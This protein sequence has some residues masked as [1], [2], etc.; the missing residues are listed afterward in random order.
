M[1]EWGDQEAWLRR[2][3]GGIRG[4]DSVH[5]IKIFAGDYYVPEDSLRQ[6]LVSRGMFNLVHLE[7]VAKVDIIVRKDEEYRQTEIA[8]RRRVRL[9]DVNVWIASREDL[10]LSKLVWAKPSHSEFQF[11]D[12]RNLIDSTID[13]GYLRQWASRLGVTDLLEHCLDERH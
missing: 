6:A 3:S 8:R 7:S 4:T 1:H 12:V 10:I 11:R 13:M 2:N 9:A 5:L